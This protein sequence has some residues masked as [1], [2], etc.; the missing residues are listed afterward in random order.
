M[1][2]LCPSSLSIRSDLLR[3]SIPT[4]IETLLAVGSALLLALSFPDLNLWFLAWL[5]FVP[6]FS[7]IIRRPHAG[8]AFF[9]GWIMATLFFYSSCYWLTYSMI[10]Y[11]GIPTLI[12]YLLLLPPCLVVG[13]FPALAISILGL[14]IKRWSSYGLL[15]APCLWVTFE[16]LRFNITGQ[17]WNALGYSQAYMPKLIQVAQWGGVYSVSFLV[18][19]VNAAITLALFKRTKENL[20]ISSI[21]IFIVASILLLSNYQSRRAYIPSG[22]VIGIQANVPIAMWRSSE[23]MANLTFQHL[24][25]SSNGLDRLEKMN[26]IDTNKGSNDIKQLSKLPRLIV[27]SESP[28]NFTYAGDAQF[29]KMVTT[30]AKENRTSMLFNSLEPDQGSGVYNS[31]VVIDENGRLAAQYN[32]IHLLPFGEYVPIPRWIPGAGLITGIVGDFTP[33]TQYPLIQIGEVKAGIFICFESTFPALT[34]RFVNQGA[35]LLINISNDGYFGK[36][37]AMKQHLANVVFRAVESRRPILR[38]TNTGIS[39]YIS[40]HGDVSDETQPFIPEERI[41][42]VGHSPYGTTFYSRYG[43]ILVGLCAMISL[44]VLL[45]KRGVVNN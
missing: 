33:G 17:L 26:Q 10:H 22:V 29:R 40:P 6:I 31:A 15:I 11:G 12:A 25:M 35:D 43:D 45:K 9:L 2:K 32:K 30:F 18:V 19:A 16:W 4:R 34:S 38:V 14:V 42:T 36:S 41:W 39:A 5:G 8:R 13:L 23:E 28:M 20:I 24:S 7:A 1:I 3:A 37:P 21:V 44:L 27:W